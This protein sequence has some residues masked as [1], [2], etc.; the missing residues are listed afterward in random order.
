MFEHKISE[1]LTGLWTG[2]PVLLGIIIVSG[3]APPARPSDPRRHLNINLAPG[4]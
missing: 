4:V 2:T 1:L 3:N